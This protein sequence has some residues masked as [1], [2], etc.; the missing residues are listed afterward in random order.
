MKPGIALF[1]LCL[2]DGGMNELPA[3]CAARMERV[4]KELRFSAEEYQN[5]LIRDVV[6]DSGTLFSECFEKW[7]NTEEMRSEMQKKALKKI[8]A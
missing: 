8:S 5:G 2:F 4:I 6:G 1:L 3:G 7:K